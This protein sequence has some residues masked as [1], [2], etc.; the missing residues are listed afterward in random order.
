MRLILLAI[1][2]TLAACSG[3]P[4]APQATDVPSNP[5]Y[6]FEGSDG[7]NTYLHVVDLNRE[8]YLRALNPDLYWIYDAAFV[9]SQRVLLLTGSGDTAR[10]PTD[11]LATV[12]ATTHR[13]VDRRA[14]EG[15]KLHHLAAAPEQGRI[16]VV[17]QTVEASAGGQP[18]VVLELDG[19]KK[20]VLRVMGMGENVLPWDVAT[21]RSRFLHL[22]PNEEFLALIYGYENAGAATTVPAGHSLLLFDQETGQVVLDEPLGRVATPPVFTP[23]S[24]ALFVAN[25]EGVLLRLDLA[26]RQLKTIY[27]APPLAY[28]APMI[29]L[30]ST[31]DG[32]LAYH[33]AGPGATQALRFDAGGQQQSEKTLPFSA[34]V[35]AVYNEGMLSLVEVT[36]EHGTAPPSFPPGG[37]DRT[38][39]VTFYHIDLGSWVMH[40]TSTIDVPKTVSSSRH[41]YVIGEMDEAP[42]DATPAEE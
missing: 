6:L 40:H 42:A 9:P 34:G 18:F 27:Q 2:L 15:Y 24:R 28:G 25:A 22:S 41:F 7:A 30:L 36:A 20:N 26:T 3:P 38:R 37:A 4:A 23:D 8:A 39:Q 21:F 31:S 5:A 10:G 29:R 16:Y 33:D 11:L 12:D 19:V 17:G 35:G 32:V 1:T 13:M 14:V